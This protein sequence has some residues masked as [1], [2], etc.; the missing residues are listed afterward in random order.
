MQK[1]KRKYIL[2]VIILLLVLPAFFIH[3]GKMPLSPDESIRA[4]V[5]LEM[6]YSGNL[7]TPTINGEYYFNKPPLYNWILLAFYKL[8]G[9][10]SEWVVRMPSLVFYFLLA[11]LIFFFSRKHTGERVA[12]IS[13]LAFLS[14]GRILFYDS[15]QGLIDSGF[16][17]MIFL[18]FML[19]F[20]LIRQEKYNLLFLVSWFL[21]ALAFLMK[22][23]PALVFQILTL[24]LAFIY[25]RKIRKL[26]TTANFLGILVFLL[27]TG[28]YYFL[29]FRQNPSGSYLSTLLNES[30]KRTFLE[31]GW[32][33][34]IIN[35]FT[36]PFEQLYHL[37]PWSLFLLLF[38]LKPVR[39][40]IRQ[41][42]FLSYLL[43]VFMVNIPVYWISVE[44]YPRYLLMLYPLLLIPA[45]YAFIEVLPV[46]RKKKRLNRVLIA[47][48]I[49]L[50][51]AGVA[52]WSTYPF[53]GEHVSLVFIPG[54]IFISACIWFA[55]R[56]PA[57][58]PEVLIIVLLIIRIGFNLL[59]IPDRYGKSRISVQKDQAIEVAAI[60]RE[61]D[62]E[63]FNLAVCSP[64]TSFY[65]AKERGE[66]LHRYHG[67][68]QKGKYYLVDDRDRLRPGEQILYRFE[69]R[70]NNSP[71]RLSVF[72]ESCYLNSQKEQK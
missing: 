61:T 10:H 36:F 42:I 47:F 55:I 6:E 7:I 3:L 52:V 50:I 33:D 43:L 29:L 26:L 68:E 4:L 70:W 60:T 8:T 15:F 32:A 35:L 57:Q 23:M 25:F 49:I 45:I 13:A 18:N 69:T 12:F 71:L 21:V 38:L 24:P 20:H 31:H 28:G 1:D 37:A 65:I 5:S 39:E 16:S 44:T 63:I 46:G 48:L 40:R 53:A 67:L 56:K 41:N 51:P 58:I 54:L 17:A 19:I 9:S 14:C 2:P 62:L 34:T 22:G 72:G 11:S 59:V 30:T 64:E 27:V 66:I